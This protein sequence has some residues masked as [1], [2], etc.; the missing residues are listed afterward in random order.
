MGMSYISL[1]PELAPVAFEYLAPFVCG[2]RDVG[3]SGGPPGGP[4]EVGP[5]GS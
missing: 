1:L 5:T 4:V 3:R 2:P